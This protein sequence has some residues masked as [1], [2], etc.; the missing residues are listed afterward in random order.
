[1]K[2]L[3]KTVFWQFDNKF[4]RKKIKHELHIYI[5]LPNSCNWLYGESESMYNPRTKEK[6]IIKEGNRGIRRQTTSPSL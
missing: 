3:L 6:C 1:M 4:L 2:L 5:Y